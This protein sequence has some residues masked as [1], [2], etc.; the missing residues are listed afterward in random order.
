[1]TAKNF[2]HTLSEKRKIQLL[3]LVLTPPLTLRCILTKAK[4]SALTVLNYC[5]GF[6][7]RMF[8]FLKNLLVKSDLNCN[9]GLESALGMGYIVQKFSNEGWRIVAKFV[10]GTSSGT[11]V[12]SAIR[13]SFINS[14]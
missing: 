12:V 1:M 13:H 7:I 2:P 5:R 8:E 11:V 4:H 14:S 10:R 9:E 6:E 3:L